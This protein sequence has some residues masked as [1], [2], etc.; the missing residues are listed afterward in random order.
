MAGSR[1]PGPLCQIQ[2]PVAIN[3]GTTPLAAM[4]FSTAL[5]LAVFGSTAPFYQALAPV[6]GAV[7]AV[8][9]SSIA[10]IALQDQ[11]IS[12]CHFVYG[13]DPYASK[14]CQNNNE[15]NQNTDQSRSEYSWC[16]YAAF[17]IAERFGAPTDALVDPHSG[18]VPDMGDVTPSANP[19]SAGEWG[20]KLS[21]AN[22]LYRKIGT[23]PRASTL[24]Q[25]LA[26][27]GKLVIATCPAPNGHVATVRPELF[28]ED[29]GA[30]FQRRREGKDD[31]PPYVAH[32]GAKTNGV[33]GVNR[34]FWP[35]VDNVSF[36]T[37]G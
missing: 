25:D 16:N 4:P 14:Q 33:M 29:F 26:N 36:F 6:F 37:P 18:P 11:A 5:G 30:L 23:Y 8:F 2:S 22:S 9:G 19:W 24:A 28:W 1:I 34:S 3:D 35:Y 32:I 31:E 15:Q 12:D 20:D 7:P 17:W 13:Y 10:L 21:A 27:Q